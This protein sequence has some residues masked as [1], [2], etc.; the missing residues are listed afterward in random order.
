[1]ITE[2]TTNLKVIWYGMSE[3]F[4]AKILPTIIMP[5]FLIL[6]GKGSFVII[7]ALIL[8]VIFDMITGLSSAY[9]SGE[10]VTSRRAVRSAY[11]LVVYGL[12]VSGS[13]LAEVIIPGQFFLEQVVTSFLGITELISIIEN[14]GKMGFAIP[15]RLLDKLEAF[16][17][18][19]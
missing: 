19:Q 4:Y 2:I 11:K 15:K 5:G 16:R 6:F 17:D 10:I 14:T 1:M 8:L 13:H 12:L 3:Y 9:V 18:N 7:Q